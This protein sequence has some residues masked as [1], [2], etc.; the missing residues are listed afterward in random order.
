MVGAVT[1]SAITTT[2]W[3]IN[4]RFYPFRLILTLSNGFDLLCLCHTTDNNNSSNNN[5][6]NKER[7]REN[8]TKSQ[9]KKQTNEQ[10]KRKKTNKK[11]LGLEL[12][13]LFK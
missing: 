1:V 3:L 9:P 2:M 10:T 11:K 6:K 13:E 12:Y 8:K 4:S 5:N 7:K